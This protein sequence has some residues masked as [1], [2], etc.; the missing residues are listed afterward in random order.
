MATTLTEGDNGEHLSAAAVNLYGAIARQEW[1]TAGQLQVE[2]PTARNELAAWGLIT[3]EAGR[4]VACDPDTALCRKLEAELDVARQRVA[5]M[6]SIPGLARDLSRDFQAAQLRV[7]GGSSIY[8]DDPAIVNARIQE[9]VGG[10]RRE[11]LAAQPGGP[12]SRKLLDIAVARDSAAL[13]RGVELHT[14][15]RDTVRDHVVTAEYARTMSARTSGRPAQYRT[16][17]AEFERMI[18]VDRQA[19]FVSDYI[20][21]GSP[22]H[23]AWLI[24]DPAAVAVLARAFESAWRWAQPWMGELRPARGQ[25]GTDT[26]TSADGVRTSPRQREI[27]RLMCSGVSQTSIA[28]KIGSSKRTLEADIAT[29]KS[30]WGVTTLNE[31]IF[32]YASSPDRL[33]D[34][35]QAAAVDPQ[36]AA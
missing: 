7:P 1:A 24:T 34:D 15:Y 18:I 35:G 5:R 23:S 14:I 19:A 21:E 28:K 4:L 16:L 11:I 13:A 22:Q 27:M 10:A 26:V 6:A 17:H 3:Y 33:V 32:Q 36:S 9:I 25:D 8:M 2:H 29:L 20:V 12:R 30:L 31:L